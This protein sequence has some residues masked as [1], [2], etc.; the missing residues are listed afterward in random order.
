MIDLQFVLSIAK[1]NHPAA[2]GPRRE[3]V[4]RWRDSPCY[5]KSSNSTH[6]D[7]TRTWCLAESVREDGDEDG[8]ADEDGDEDD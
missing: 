2:I 7:W 3:Q 6:L 5:E 1:G 8:D 4:R